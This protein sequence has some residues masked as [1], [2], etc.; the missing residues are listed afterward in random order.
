MER[1]FAVIGFTLLLASLIASVLGTVPSLILGGV[2]FFCFLLSFFIQR[3]ESRRYFLCVLLSA[4]VGLSVFTSYTILKAEP[5]R[6]LVGSSAVIKGRVTRSPT[7]NGERYTYY[8]ETEAFSQENAPQKVKLLLTSKEKI[9]AKVNDCI[10]IEAGIYDNGNMGDYSKGYFLTARSLGSAEITPFQSKSFASWLDSFREDMKAAIRQSLPGDEGDIISAMVLGDDDNIDVSITN[11]FRQ[12]GVSH[13][14]AVSGLHLSLWSGF[15]YVLL[16][17]ILHLGLKPSSLTAIGFTLF[18]M[19]L[20][21]FSMS[22]LRA[23]IMVGVM[24]LGRAFLKTADGLNSLGLAAGLLCLIFPYAVYSVSFLLTVSAC[25]GIFTLGIY[26]FQKYAH[27]FDRFRLGKVFS[28]L[29]NSVFLSF[30]ILVFTFPVQLVYFKEFA[31]LSLI[32]NLIFI[33]LGSFSIALGGLAAF[34]SFAPFISVPAAFLSGLGAKAMIFCAK[35]FAQ[36]PVTTV[37]IGE[38]YLLLCAAA[39]LILLAAALLM[40]RKKA[41]MKLAAFLSAA[42]FFLASVS[43]F[44]LNRDFM[45]VTV[46]DNGGVSVLLTYKGS[47]VLVG[48][49]AYAPSRVRAALSASQKHQI[50]LLV[51]PEPIEDTGAELLALT[52]LVDIKEVLLPEINPAFNI[53]AEKMTEHSNLAIDLPNGFR[54]EYTYVDGHYAVAV[55]WENNCI[56]IADREGYFWY[57]EKAARDIQILIS[58]SSLPSLGSESLQ[59]LCGD[60]Y[61]MIKAEARHNKGE[62]VVAV[63]GYGNLKITL[64]QNGSYQ[65]RRE[66]GWQQS[67]KLN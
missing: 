34:S 30:S 58:G 19:A 53:K 4:V 50:D 17:K 61:D 52:N 26:C 14:F 48:C 51:L 59:V 29:A 5:A 63:G 13:L 22:V 16:R 54:V 40:R 3:K 32:S 8:L 44:A 24:L 65:I 47:S 41:M 62:N 42:V 10:T 20:T 31:P 66:Q 57:R 36:F 39:A 28:W 11:A 33:P 45:K 46:I 38:P 15:I 56:L 60:V 25:L 1:P 9:P 55:L 35:A 37:G 43:H 49:G 64:N 27:S 23:G 7:F 6:R 21:G 2:L 12:S 18:Y 67:A